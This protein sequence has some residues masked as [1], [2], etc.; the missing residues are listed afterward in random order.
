MVHQLHG[1]YID[2]IYQIQV[3]PSL[4]FRILT[5]KFTIY[6]LK[7][8]PSQKQRSKIQA[9]KKEFLRLMQKNKMR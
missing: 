4:Q 7:Y 9:A 3:S 6:I 5:M 8:G 1:L 2:T